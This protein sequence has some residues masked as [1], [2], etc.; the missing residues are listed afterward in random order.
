MQHRLRLW[1]RAAVGIGGVCRHEFHRRRAHRARKGIDIF[2]GDADCGRAFVALAASFVLAARARG[3]ARRR[4]RHRSATMRWCWRRSRTFLLFVAAAG[5]AQ[6]CHSFYYAFGT[7]NWKALGYSAD[8]I[9]FLWA[10]GVIAE[11]VLLTF[12]ARARRA[13][14]TGS[15]ARRSARRSGLVR[16][17]VL[18]FSPPLWLLIPVQCLHAGTFCAAHLGAM[19]FIAARGAASS[20]RRRRRAST[21]R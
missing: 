3:A 5:I 8:L 7:L 15:A 6:A 10:L 16:W 18:A 17:T 12:S 13:A 1:A 19:H 4:S 14:R 11:I 21:A 20:R 2:P 9:G